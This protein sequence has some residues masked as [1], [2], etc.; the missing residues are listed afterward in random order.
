MPIPTLL[1][2]VAASGRVQP[3]AIQL[4]VPPSVQ[5]GNVVANGPR[6]LAISWHV[7]DGAHDYRLSFDQGG[8]ARQAGMAFRSVKVD[9]VEPHRV[10]TANLTDLKPGVMVRYT[11]LGD[12]KTLFKG[13]VMAPKSDRQPFTM[14]VFGDCGADT[15]EEAQVAYQ[16]YLTKPDML[17]LT[18]DMVYSR[19]RAS[20]YRKNFFPY[21]CSELASPKNGAPLLSSTLVVGSAGNH[22]ILY[23]EF[24]KWGDPLAYFYYWSQPLNGP[25]TEKGAKNSPTISGP[26]PRLNAFLAAAGSNYPRMANFSY[27]YGN[28]HFTVL[29]SNPYVDWTDPTMREW[30]KKDLAAAAKKTWRFVVYH[31]PGFHSS[32]SHQSEKQ[33]R[34]LAD[35]FE[36]GK[37]DVVFNGHVHNYQRTKPI[38]V[39]NKAGAS[40]EE[41]AKD[42]WPV[43]GAFDGVKNTRPKGVVYIVDGAGG[44]DLYEPEY[45]KTPELWKPF[46]KV[47][48]GE[49]SFSIVE[50][51]GKKF[52][53]RQIHRS[54]KEIDR[55]TIT[56]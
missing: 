41:L 20:E 48:S 32:K 8:R 22:D 36:E 37:V 45:E 2:L 16:T 40:K 38:Q 30:V 9:G 46:Q 29:D 31:H 35:L 56:K 39:G 50:V 21:Y 4:I 49:Y 26:E 34:A 13:E 53:L 42:D 6:S 55:M 12:G 14:A 44:A 54:G 3:Q 52:T 1:V 33:M 10:Y 11:L 23:R 28:A 18:G 24:D 15:P 5:L 27:D 7:D 25:L 47:Y 43:D 17:I 51:N 19:G